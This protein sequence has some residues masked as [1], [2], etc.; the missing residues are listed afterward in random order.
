MTI[1]TF[2]TYSRIVAQ[3][4]R[5][6]LSRLYG[7][8]IAFCLTGIFALS[9]PSGN[10]DP[11]TPFFSC[12]LAGSPNGTWV[13]NP[14]V[15]RAFNCCGTTAPDKC[16]EFSI[17]LSPQAVAINFQIASGAIPPGA[18]FYQIN[19]GPQIAVGSP[20]CLNGPGPYSLTFCKP[21]NNINTYAITSIAGPSVSPPDSIGQGCNTIMY[22][23]GLLENSS[24]SWNSIS[25]GAYG[26]YNSYLSCTSGCDT[27]VVTAQPGAPPYVDYV[28]CGTPL[29]N[30][31]SPNPFFCDTIRI[32]FS[33][34]LAN[35]VNP[36]PATFCANNPNGV[37]LTGS[38]SGGFPPYTYA[39]TN[40][41]NGTGTVVGS[42]LSYTATAGGNY[43]FIVYDKNYPSCPPRITNVTVTV[44]PTPVVNA[45]PDQTLCGN[46]VQL[47]GSV[48]GATGGVWSGGNGTY[49]PSNTSGNAVYAP[50]AAELAAG[51]LVLAYTSTGNGV[52][53]PVT[54][55]VVIN[56]SP[57]VNVSLSAPPVV[58]FGQTATITANVS[59]GIAPF[60]YLWNN[61]QTSQ[62]ISN[63][64]AGTYS[65][66]V[67]GNGNGCVGS[68]MVNINPNPQ[69]FVNTSPNNSISCGT[70]ATISASASG[71]TG[72]LNYSWSNG[73]T[74]PSATVNTGTYII[75]VTDAV[76]CT[77]TNTV[78]VTSSNSTLLVNVN[79]PPVLC[80][81]ATT[82]LTAVASGGFGGY[83]YA[84]S[85]GPNTSSTVAG[86][87]N[88]CITVTDA[89]ACVT[90]ACITVTQNPPLTVSVPAPQTICNGASTTVSAF[91]N[92]GQAPYTYSWN[93]GQ[94]SQTI[95]APAGT[96][97]V[98]VT[99]AIGCTATVPVTVSQAPVLNASP[100]S[101]AVSCFGG[102]NGSASANV[103][104][105]TP[106][107]YYSW[108][109]YGGSSAMATGL[110]TGIFT[111][112]VTDAIGCS[113]TA[114]VAVNQPPAITATVT[115]NNNVSCNGGNNGSATVNTAGGTPGYYYSWTPNGGTSQTA[116]NLSA[117]T[118]TVNITDT[119]GCAQTA[120]ITIGQS[121][122]LT[123]GT[124]SITD[125]T[126]NGGNNGSATVSGSGGTPGYTYLWLPGGVNTATANNLSAGNYTATITDALGCMA[127]IPVTISQPTTLTASVSVINQ[128]SCNG[129]NNGSA[130]VT[131]AGGSPPYTYSW[132][133]TP[134]QTNS[135]ATNLSAG[136][137]LA[138]ITD[139][140]GC[141]ITSP[142][143]TITQPTALTVTATPS[144][145]ISCNTSI[146][147]SAAASGGS[148][149]YSYSW[150]TGAN[151]YSINV[152][153]GTYNVT[154]T[155]GNGCTAVASVSVQASNSTLSASITSPPAICYGSTT[156]LSVTPSGGF[157][158]YSYQWTGGQTSQSI[159]AGAGNYCVSVTD[160]G[161]CSTTA[162]ANIIQNQPLAAS[163][164]TPPVICPGAMT[165]I[166]ASGSGGQAPFSY[167]WNTGQTTQS[168]A[169]PAG[170]YTVVISDATGSSCSATATV[171][172]TQEAPIVLSL[173]STNVSCFGGNNGTASVYASGGM[174]GYTYNWLPSGGTNTLATNLQPGNYTVSVTDAIGCV[175]Y[176][177]ANITQPAS[178]VTASATATN[179]S[180]FG[181]ANGSATVTGSG[182]NP[183][184]SYYWSNTGASTATITGIGTGTYSVIVA[185]SSGCSTSC[186]VTVT[187]PPAIT[188]S[189]NGTGTSC[190]SAT[191]SATVS[192]T[193]GAGAY[194]YTWSPG[195]GNGP[196]AN[197]LS[198]GN[199]T[200]TVGDANGCQ[201]QIK[202]AVPITSSP[203][204][205]SFT[206][207]SSCLN[208]LTNYTDLS[209]AGADSI[210]SWNWNFG[211]PTSG[212][213]NSS[214]LQNPSHMYSST[215]TYTATLL[216]IAQSGCYDSISVIVTVNPLPVA[217]FTW[218]TACGGLTGF[219]ST[220][221][222]NGGTLTNWSWN[223]GDINS[224]PANIST[225]QNPSHIY[226]I[227]GS[228]TVI[229]TVASNNGCLGTQTQ[230]ITVLP[231]PTADF[232]VQSGCKNSPTTFTDS[233]T[234]AGGTITNWLWD[235]GDGS[236]TSSAQNPSHVY[237]NNGTFTVTLSI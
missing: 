47:N 71:G 166:T 13:S 168:V 221:S 133:T 25:P 62:S 33:P 137:Y 72:T 196:I 17:T 3:S 187:A 79:Q 232:N 178:A 171:N 118:F 161:G 5:S 224:G 184:Y 121:S 177:T 205:A 192:A 141:V 64:G 213:S 214:S 10:C 157:G 122:L 120:Q 164:S 55:Q 28:V 7:F 150:N 159:I 87:G 24:L 129:G 111:I 26:A 45:G 86:A 236:A 74:T 104:G 82:T 155:D 123:A 198:A 144:S 93:T 174:P 115:L 128:V 101:V 54:D 21:G 66:T 102:N 109:P 235:F 190:G 23:L 158:N 130:Q 142:G 88:Y 210:V 12:N 38:V 63:V 201:E 189:Y 136:N 22:A 59:G 73:A 106:A 8:I 208:T 97:T 11:G 98:T 126:C 99:D 78:S 1:P 48:T 197:N 107:Y 18:L 148:G 105:G 70:T 175:A 125:V 117:G 100:A 220:S 179:A 91:P 207:T 77:A 127:S 44:T 116:N 183:P 34:P 167:A 229:L 169:Q 30:S 94:A 37:V 76:G 237:T 49:S 65:V 203:V 170:N 154:A 193:G 209:S 228:Y 160:G 40:G 112:T 149:A 138:T 9:Q 176:G 163:I 222:I 233:S 172:I 185:D 156:T 83:T 139:S 200:V 219:G 81:G 50:T 15:S 226:S 61:G 42:N 4:R 140:K 60:T 52:C 68:A 151:T 234:V 114:T 211:E 113:K 85:N 36:N 6:P 84:W 217:S 191:G 39:W 41:S 69:I 152:G 186:S 35:P 19:C 188:L 67:M 16:I 20:I 147:I 135:V 146:T 153:T 202:V 206:A 215:G 225:L 182:S 230:T 181:Q 180:C 110:M 51:T 134:V 199:Y 56:I 108:T 29:A 165:T 43:S 92:G 53:N 58:C 143:I 131:A 75:T 2:L 103:S 57:P 223:F 145:Y 204:S 27:T 227:P 231:V 124:F 194:S 32:Y 195:A 173:G 216:V 162:C 119:Y 96:Y 89:G 46:T 212:S 218:T 14:P 31:C 95:N 132:N 90:S 80:N